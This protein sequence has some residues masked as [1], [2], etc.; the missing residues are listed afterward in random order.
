MFNC[1]DWGELVLVGNPYAPALAQHRDGIPGGK[2]HLLHLILLG[3]PPWDL[4]PPFFP[5]PPHLLPGPLSTT[6]PLGS[7]TLAPA[8]AHVNS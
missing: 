1:E 3:I 6:P 8:P 7:L 5:Q 4:P 2:L